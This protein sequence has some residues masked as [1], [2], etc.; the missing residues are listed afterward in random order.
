MAADISREHLQQIWDRCNLGDI[1]HVT[2][3][4]RG[5]INLCRIVND[6]HV[7]RFDTLDYEQVDRFQSEAL[8]Y[9][10]LHGTEVPVPDV[11]RV[12][13]SKSLVPYR[14][15]ILTKLN[16]TT[17]SDSWRQLSDSQQGQ[18]AYAVGRCL[19]VIHEQLFEGFGML[20]NLP[21]RS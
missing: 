9:E 8:A 3:P 2:S 13:A 10:R 18:V 6:R 20:F 14:Y 16:G 5:V 1:H 4:E 11:I 12:D 19:A 15:I 7:I 21:E 17:V